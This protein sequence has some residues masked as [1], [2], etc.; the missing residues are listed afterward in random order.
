LN[1]TWGAPVLNSIA[2]NPNPATIS[3]YITIS[4]DGGSTNVIA[5]GGNPDFN[6]AIENL[7]Q[8]QWVCQS[9]VASET[10]YLESIDVG[11]YISWDRFRYAT[12]YEYVSTDTLG[13]V[14]S[15]SPDTWIRTYTSCEATPS[16]NIDDF[17]TATLLTQGANYFFCIQRGTES[18]QGH[19]CATDSSD[20]NYLYRSYL[21]DD[22]GSPV[23]RTLQMQVNVS[24]SSPVKLVAILPSGNYE[25]NFIAESEYFFGNPSLVTLPPIL[26]G[27]TIIKAKLYSA[28]DGWSGEAQ[29]TFTVVGTPTDSSAS[30]FGINIVA[31]D[32]LEGPYSS[33][34]PSPGYLHTYFGFGATSNGGF[35]GK[36]LVDGT[37]RPTCNLDWNCMLDI[38]TGSHEY[39]LYSTVGGYRYSGDFSVDVNTGMVN[40]YIPL[41]YNIFDIWESDAEAEKI[42][43]DEIYSLTAHGEVSTNQRIGTGL[44]IDN[45]YTYWNSVFVVP[46]NCYSENSISANYPFILPG[47][48]TGGDN[49]AIAYSDSDGMEVTIT[50]VEGRPSNCADNVEL[51]GYCISFPA[52]GWE[53]PEVCY[54]ALEPTSTIEDGILGI[55]LPGSIL[56]TRHKDGLINFVKLYED[57]ETVYSGYTET[58]LASAEDWYYSPI[59]SV[60]VGM[61]NVLNDD[62]NFNS[63]D[64]ALGANITCEATLQS[65]G[66]AVYDVNFLL[67]TDQNTIYAQASIQPYKKYNAYMDAEQAN[68]A[69]NTVWHTFNDVNANH[70]GIVQ[71]AV[72]TTNELGFK[73]GWNFS[74]QR[75]MYD[76]DYSAGGGINVFVQYED[77][78]PSYLG[79][80]SPYDGD[81]NY[82]DLYNWNHDPYYFSY[83]TGNSPFTLYEGDGVMIFTEDTNSGMIAKK[84][85]NIDRGDQFDIKL[86]LPNKD[87]SDNSPVIIKNNITENSLRKMVTCK[88][89]FY[90]IDLDFNKAFFSFWTDKEGSS[91]NPLCS[92]NQ[93]PYSTN[94]NP[95]DSPCYDG[96]ASSTTRDNC[97]SDND[98]YAKADFY[99]RECVS[100]TAGSTIGHCS[101]K[102]TD[103]NGNFAFAQSFMPITVENYDVVGL[104][105]SY[106]LINNE[107]ESLIF[108]TEDD[109]IVECIVYIEQI[110][111]PDE[112]F[113][114]TFEG[115]TLSL[116]NREFDEYYNRGYLIYRG[117]VTS[118]IK[119]LALKYTTDNESWY[120][121]GTVFI[122]HPVYGTL[123]APVSI[124]VMLV[125]SREETRVEYSERD[126]AQFYDWIESLVYG[127]MSNPVQTFQTRTFDVLFIILGI[128]IFIPL[129]LYV[130]YLMLKFKMME[131]GE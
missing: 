7:P 45:N 32:Y 100:M 12:L 76:S 52:L 59:V 95:K 50:D 60:G 113:T 68:G 117:E 40:I 41:T 58:K 103:L 106:A 14:L 91:E 66:F 24:S 3:N 71:C 44:Y 111:S 70:T 121:K 17:N 99:A 53:C 115:K 27:S 93:Y 94:C 13:T 16:Y 2:V 47:T 78:T 83:D 124:A 79:H 29:T 112:N 21:L 43:C 90:D 127:M 119:N 36:I 96:G 81:M 82:F 120:G 80:K 109:G 62:V 18:S 77:G 10:G 55:H 72:Q 65:Y 20:G 25:S 104:C 88:T 63:G 11:P 5:A 57:A 123:D 128:I 23:N 85:F 118:E 49:L 98:C 122:N 38:G 42:S 92:S 126:A 101:V 35:L 37:A 1:N 74:D 130:V 15:G 19:L 105:E 73:S 56:G 97:G 51:F 54:P 116:I 4:S 125:D 64:F 129:L 114:V 67:I 48:R 46:K 84:T 86:Y 107:K 26:S 33:S 34:D 102:V 108:T 69:F 131:K 110:S 9:F 89:Y 75:Y 22:L 87:S 30:K 28:E 61:N 31:A 39:V 6:A 8:Q